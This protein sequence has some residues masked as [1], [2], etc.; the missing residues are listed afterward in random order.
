MLI[1]GD[2]FFSGVWAIKWE[3]QY[4]GSGSGCCHAELGVETT[5]STPV[6]PANIQTSHREIVVSPHPI[7]I[8]LL[9]SPPCKTAPF[10]LQGTSKRSQPS[11]SPVIDIKVV[12]R[13]AELELELLNIVHD[14]Y[15]H[16]LPMVT[17]M[18][19]ATQRTGNIYENLASA[20]LDIYCEMPDQS[21]RWLSS[22]SQADST[23]GRCA[24]VVGQSNRQ[25]RTFM[26]LCGI[27]VTYISRS[28]QKMVGVPRL[29]AH[30]GIGLD[31]LLL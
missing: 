2:Q 23:S 8:A 22:R 18:L 7:L 14:H 9:M 6:V 5:W 19:T 17:P 29:P 1:C 26:A 31:S 4:S 28:C 30:H 16:N 15:G 24:D 10:G 25:E 20:E 13:I 11:R 21:V 27:I 3:K 12:H